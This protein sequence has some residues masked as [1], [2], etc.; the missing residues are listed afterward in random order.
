MSAHTPGPWELFDN[1]EEF[2]RREAA[3]IGVAPLNC[4]GDVAHCAGFNS[5]R[6]VEEELANARLMAAAPELLAACER[7]LNWLSSYPGG[8][9]ENAYLQARAAVDKATRA[10]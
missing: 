8:C 9:A 4:S 1:G 7:A 3:R 10:V 6:P 5:Q 2:K